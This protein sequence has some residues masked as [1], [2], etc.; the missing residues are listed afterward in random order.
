MSRGRL[1]HCWWVSPQGIKLRVCGWSLVVQGHRMTQDGLP[2]SVQT[3]PYPALLSDSRQCGFLSLLC[4]A[5]AAQTPLGISWLFLCLDITTLPE[6]SA[7]LGCAAA[8]GVR[9][10]CIPICW[11]LLLR[12]VD[13]GTRNIMEI[14]WKR[15]EM[16]FILHAGK[17]HSKWK[18]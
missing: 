17:K 7:T 5:D 1:Q 16:S 10:V 4:V 12:E 3:C 15:D 13:L 2:V 8:Q 6:L 18:D 9:A 11:E 14:T